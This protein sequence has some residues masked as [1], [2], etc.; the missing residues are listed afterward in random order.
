MRI[1]AYKR[2]NSKTAT[3]EAAVKAALTLHGLEIGL[4][5]WRVEDTAQSNVAIEGLIA[6]LRPEDVVA[7]AEPSVLSP[8]ATQ[9]LSYASQIMAKGVRI[10]CA[11]LPGGRM[12]LELIREHLEPLRALEKQ[13]DDLNAQLER[14]RKQHDADFGEFAA[15]FEKRTLEELQK[16]GVRLGAILG[17]NFKMPDR[18]D[19]GKALT[20]LRE[21]LKLSMDEAGKLI[22][23][24]KGTISRI[25]AQGEAAA[26]YAEYAEALNVQVT[27]HRAAQGSKKP[28]KTPVAPAPKGLFEQEIARLTAERVAS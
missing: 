16:R 27:L 8:K 28:G 14:E 4:G 19:Q 24:D 3:Q 18:P 26:K 20:A 15:S 6:Q 5:N 13:V 9:M 23:A 21:E 12:D 25:E 17:S 2:P 22:G 1:F 11:S 10:I 7:I